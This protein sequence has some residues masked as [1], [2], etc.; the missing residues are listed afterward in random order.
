MGV[1]GGDGVLEILEARITEL[2]EMLCERLLH[3]AAR[4]P[5]LQVVA[6]EFP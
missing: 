2:N 5:L 1:G 6:P 4:G 3:L